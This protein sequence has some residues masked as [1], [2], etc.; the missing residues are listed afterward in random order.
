MGKINE[1][2]KQKS[3]DFRDSQSIL[4]IQTY[5]LFSHPINQDFKH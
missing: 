4:E 5:D 3:V 1:L 2:Q